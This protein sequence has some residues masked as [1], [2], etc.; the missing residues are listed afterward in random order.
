MNIE[1]TLAQAKE[2]LEQILILQEK[3]LIWNIPSEKLSDNGFLTIQHDLTLLDSMNHKA[4]QIIAKDG[5]KVVGFALVML[6]EFKDTV[7]LLKPMFEIFNNVSYKGKLL[8]QLNYYVLGQ[9]CVD[10][11]Y[12][13]QG[14]FDKLY[15]KHKEIYSRKFELCLTEVA[16]KN[17]RSMKAH[18][19]V[20]LKKFIPSKTLCKNGISCSGTGNNKSQNLHS[21]FYF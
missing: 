2:E 20:A 5:E 7:P 14:I 21:G 1:I 9:I 4:K 19:R 13:G 8:S 10:L 15:L 3:N 17:E 16:V 6:K 11:H 12:R 18:E